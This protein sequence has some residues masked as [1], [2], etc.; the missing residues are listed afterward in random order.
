MSQRYSPLCPI[1]TA[2]CNGVFPEE[3]GRKKQNLYS[4]FDSNSTLPLGLSQLVF[5]VGGR[6]Y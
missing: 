1:I 5:K 2:R 4:A 6:L 3:R